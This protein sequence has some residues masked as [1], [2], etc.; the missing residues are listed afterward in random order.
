MLKFYFFVSFVT[1]YIA[2]E[3]ANIIPIIASNGIPLLVLGCKS[4][5][6]KIHEPINNIQAIKANTT[7]L[8]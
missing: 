1:L 4:T 7:Y 8:K 2:K 6:A 5:V 3:I